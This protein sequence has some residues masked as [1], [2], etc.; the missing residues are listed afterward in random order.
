M[1]SQEQIDF[2]HANGYLIMPA[3]IRVRELDLLQTAMK[4]L[5]LSGTPPTSQA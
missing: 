1:L 3:L 2:F 4:E 5:A